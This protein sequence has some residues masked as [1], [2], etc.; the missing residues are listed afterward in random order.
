MPQQPQDWRAILTNL[1]A[2]IHISFYLSKREY[3]IARWRA[4]KI[5]HQLYM[6]K[7]V[8]AWHPCYLRKCDH[9]KARESQ[10][11][12]QPP[13]RGQ[14]RNVIGYRNSE[15]TIQCMR[16]AH[17]GKV[18]SQAHR[19]ALRESKL[20]RDAASGYVPPYRQIAGQLKERI[21]QGHWKAGQQLPNMVDAA[22][23]FRVDKATINKAYRL[24]AEEHIVVIRPGV[25]TFLDNLP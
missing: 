4:E 13:P 24:L 10:S 7:E 20:R 17:R 22:H 9:F 1:P 15:Q 8:P 19:Q 5:L 18:L 14:R 16:A 6:G 12:V 3:W 11:N 2:A 21:Q 23:L 25:G